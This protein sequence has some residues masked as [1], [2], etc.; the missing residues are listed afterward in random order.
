MAP[1]VID[2]G[3]AAP[4]HS[5]GGGAGL[6]M[7][8]FLQ[9]PETRRRR[10]RSSNRPARRS[11][12]GGPVVMQEGCLKSQDRSRRC[13]AASAAS[14]AP[15]GDVV[16]AITESLEPRRLLASTWGAAPQ[17]IHQDLAATDFP[18]LTGKGVA[19][20]VMDTGIDYTNP[21]LGGGF[22]PG[23]KVIA[24][25][26]FV[27]NDDDPID[28]FGHGT[29]VAGIIAADRFEIGGQTYQGVAPDANLVALRVSDGTNPV[30]DATILSA[31]QWIEQ[32]YQTYNIAAVNVSFG[33]GTFTTDVTHQGV[34]EE[35]RK[36]HN[37]G[38]LFVSP[39]GNGGTAGGEGINWPA[40]DPAVTA[41]GSVN[42]ADQISTFTQRGANLDLLAPGEN[43]GTTK[44]GGGTQLVTLSSFSSPVVAGAAALLKQADPSLTARDELSIL[45]AGGATHVDTSFGPRQFYPRIDLENAIALAVR[46]APDP[47]SDVGAA[48]ASTSSDLAYDP[49][50][51]LHF[52][53]YDQNLRTIKYATRDT[54][55]LWSAT[56]VVDR[57][58]DDVGAT[59]SLALDPTGKPSIAN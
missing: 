41:V 1:H 55:G 33:S 46:R 16:V 21:L 30:T 18:S 38:I 25:H 6:Q 10:R 51:V 5:G 34:S 37:L 8:I 23:H 49:Q 47:A 11:A 36:L 13:R 24:G 20:A 28:T 29:N 35:Y 27:D 9:N 40:A 58:G 52:A 57:G 7:P 42:T 32:N 31:L 39:S 4:R 26:D 54:A 22:G 15:A 2:G 53:Y 14:A 50:G 59:L 48:G 43:V 56:Q 3:G 44:I 12:A 17:L 19:V 45:R